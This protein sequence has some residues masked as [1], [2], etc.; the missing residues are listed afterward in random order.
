[1]R[2]I[3]LVV[4]LFALLAASHAQDDAAKG[5]MDAIWNAIDKRV[6]Q[7]IDVWFDDGEFPMAIQLLRVQYAM[8]PNDYE[9]A[10]NLGWMLENVEEPDLAIAVYE[11]YL[12][13]NPGDVDAALPIAQYYF[14]KKRD[15]E[16]V[17]ELLNPILPRKPHAN[18]YRI[19]AHSYERTNKL[20]DSRR[21]WLALLEINPDDGAARRLLERVEEKIKAG[22][23]GG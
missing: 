12:K 1:M 8:H 22:G 18:A 20:Q 7:Q 6:A 11:R 21:V 9:I 2:F 14:Q 3:A 4:S 19:L 13:E 17:I 16:K 5:R 10:T 15:Y 23:G